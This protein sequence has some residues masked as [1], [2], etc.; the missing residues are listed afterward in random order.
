MQIYAFD[1]EGDSTDTQHQIHK[2]MSPP[3][4]QRAVSVNCVA[5]QGQVE[6]W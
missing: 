2:S 3:V 4:M 1:D 5:A 6:V